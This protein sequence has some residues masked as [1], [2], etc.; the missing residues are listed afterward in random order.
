[1]SDQ[2]QPKPEAKPTAGDFPLPDPAAFARN[3]VEVA[4][5]SQKLISDFLKRKDDG[6]GTGVIDPLNVS[7][8]FIDLLSHMMHEPRRI[9][10]AQATLWSGHLKLW[11]NTYKRLMGEDFEAVAPAAKNDKR[12]RDPAWTENQI[13]DF[14]K[15]S[16][17]LT[18]NWLHDTVTQVD[19]LDEKARKKIDFYT[20]QFI[21]AISPS[22]FVL[23]NPEVLKETLRSNGEN[24][25]RGLTHV[26]EDLERGEGKLAIRQ[27]DESKF[28]VGENLA[29]TPGKVVFQNAL[30]QLVQ[31]NPSTD[32]V[33]ER[34]LLIVPPWINKYYIL[35]L[36]PENSFIRWAVAQG[37]TVFIVSWINPDEHLAKKRF[38][39]Y[40]TEGFY[41]AVNAVQAATGAEQINVIGYCIGGTLTA[42]ALA[43]MA[44]KK[45]KRITAATFFTS[46][47]DF[48]EAGDL[49]VFIDDEQLRHM[50]RIME[51]Q[52]GYLDGSEMATTFN[53]LR[54]NDL[55]WSFVVNNYLLGKDPMAFDILY[56]NGDTTR[57]PVAMHMQYLRE[58]YRDNLLSQGKMKLDGVKIDLSKITIPVFLQSSKEDHIAPAKSVFKAL[59]S[60]KGPTEFMMAGS[61]HIAGV[62]NPP[63]ANKYQFWAN[64]KPAAT[65]DEWRAGAVETPGS[66]WHYWDKWL[67]PK[68][69]KKVKARVPGDGKLKPI[70][71]APGSYVKMK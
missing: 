39:N 24:L 45:D 8:A 12:F 11:E 14:I 26:I 44:T 69:G 20:K 50:E 22:N 17:L 57:M 32:E 68:S 64:T 5:R 62:V 49:Q 25:V 41:E 23:T 63:S 16:Y 56:W 66:W 28:K 51:A 35:D 71:D 65:L 46:Q 55:I 13:F 34:P 33:F 52:G 60:F 6:I 3:M 48:S 10:E 53:M 38:D 47:V 19:G 40:L 43:H 2:K 36:K 42:A 1:M 58:C 4:K 15:Q 61:G 30:M 27:V 59:R 37:Y 67:A 70:E 7:N 31:F 54:S 21:D 29:T 9:M 18:A